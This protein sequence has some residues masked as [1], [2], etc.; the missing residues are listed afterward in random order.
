[1]KTPKKSSKSEI[2]LYKEPILK[3]MIML[4]L[5][6]L[7]TSL[8]K[9]FHNMVDMFFLARMNHSNA[10]IASSIAAINIHFPTN[11]LFM[12]IGSGLAVAAITIIR[13]CKRI[14]RNDLAVKYASKIAF[15]AF[16]MGIIISLIMFVLAPVIAKIMNAKGTTLDYAVT[17]FKI[18]SLEILPVF[19]FLTYQGIRHAE[20]QSILPKIFNSVSIVINIFFSWL[21]VRK[22]DMGVTGAAWSTLIS[23]AF[24][25]PFVLYGLFFNKRTLSVNIKEFFP[26]QETSK[27]ILKL[28]FPAAITTALNALG[29][30]VLT[31]RLLGYSEDVSCGFAVGNRIA[32]IITSSFTP[33]STILTTYLI[34]NIEKNNHLRARKSY[35]T[36]LCFMVILSTVLAGIAILLRKPLIYLLM[37]RNMPIDYNIAAR[38]TF[39]LLFTQPFVAII[40]VDNSYFTATGYFNY[41]FISTL[42]RLWAIRIPILFLL[43]QIF[44]NVVWNASWISMV[45]SNA[46][47]I[48]V[49][50]LLKKR[51]TLKRTV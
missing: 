11:L 45:V 44:T 22:L 43:G 13:Q 28:M 41:S 12:S 36:A 1:M 5:P 9:S 27:V 23:Q 20:D 15:A 25:L 49:N 16:I 3:G 2:I 7:I 50:Y 34:E 21:F 10:D 30:M 31:G 29:F 33:I 47:I 42:I 38:F 39:W 17:Y 40:W 6:I 37:S 18:R 26:D 8:I 32:A 51:I 4:S 48:F 24:T 35:L 14:N 19:L 46:I